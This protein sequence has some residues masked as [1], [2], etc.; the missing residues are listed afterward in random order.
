MKRAKLTVISLILSICLLFTSGCELLDKLFSEGA[1]SKIYGGDSPFS[2]H[3]VDVGQG[4]CTLIRI[5][6]HSIL[7]DAGDVD[8]DQKVLAY[9]KSAGVTTLDLAIATHPHADHIGGMDSVVKE[10]KPEKL[11]MP[12]IK[13][14]AVPT[15]KVYEDLLL[16][17]KSAGVSVTWAEPGQVFDIGGAEVK[18]FGP[19]EEFDDLNQCSV[20]CRVE[21]GGVSVL[22][23]GDAEKAGESGVLDQAEQGALQ[24]TIFKAGHHGS[25]TSNTAAFL[26]AAAP[27]YVVISCGADNSYGHPHKEALKRFEQM[28]S[29]V[30]RT[31]QNGTVV[32]SLEGDKIEV[33][34]EK[35]A[36]S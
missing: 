26:K 32:L 2:V 20:V 4:D 25:K 5:G 1:A 10:Y 27:D 16:S 9:M 23:S 28:K 6:D 33:T 36:Q 12:H 11:I 34:L 17:I 19:T 35:G 8:C 13:K 7:V 22:L 21:Y 3:F 29:E 14:S 15:T 24:S 31:D 30:Y 18:I